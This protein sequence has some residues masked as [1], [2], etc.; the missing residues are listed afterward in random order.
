MSNYFS[1]FPI[2]KY[3]NIFVRDL[4]KRTK[5]IE[6]NF[7]NPYIFLPYTVKEDEKPEDIAYYY[8]GSTDETWL[9][10]LANNIID[11]YH[12]WPLNEEQFNK[13]LIQKYENISGR[14]GYGVVDW[15]SNEMNDDNIL[16]YY[17]EIEK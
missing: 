1:K 10:L 2:I 7:S 14:T 9:V 3:D 6:K 8:Y 4:T 13:Y 17:K 12:E 11:P 15:T 16:F 5:F